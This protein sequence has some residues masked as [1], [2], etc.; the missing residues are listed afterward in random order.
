MSI[1]IFRKTTA[2]AEPLPKVPMIPRT[3]NVSPPVVPFGVLAESLSPQII[4]AIS[5]DIIALLS[6][7]N[8]GARIALV[9]PHLDEL[10]TLLSSALPVDFV[11]MKFAD[12]KTWKGYWVHVRPDPPEGVRCSLWSRVY[13]PRHK[14]LVMK[15]TP[16]G[17]HLPKVEVPRL[18]PV[19]LS[20]NTLRM[21]PRHNAPSPVPFLYPWLG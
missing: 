1:K 14:R 2:L 12:C 5:R 9:S 18:A 4:S 6:T 8:A 13:D 20:P 10:R 21:P 15:P 7:M 11:T 3:F 19:G 16:N 17:M